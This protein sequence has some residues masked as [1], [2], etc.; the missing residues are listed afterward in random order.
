MDAPQKGQVAKLIPCSIVFSVWKRTLNL[1][2]VLFTENGIKY[3]RV[4]GSISTTTRRKKILLDFQEQ[5][6]IRVL[7]MTLGTGAVGYVFPHHT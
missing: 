4:D 1:V 3:C 5:D 2:E 6:D 7:L